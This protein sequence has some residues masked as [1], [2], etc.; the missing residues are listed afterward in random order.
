ME[1][2]YIYIILIVFTYFCASTPFGYLLAKTKNIDI[3]KEGSGN[4]GATNILRTIGFPYFLLVAILDV[5]KI[6][7]PIFLAQR[8]GLSDTH[9][10]IVMFIAIMGSMYSFWLNFKGGK[11]VSA[12]FAALLCIIGVKYFLMF[13]AIWLA[14][15]YILKIMSVTN[16]IIV[17]ILPII[18]YSI[19]PNSTP[20]IYLSLTFIP[21]IWWSH[22]ENIKRL[23]KGKEPKI[24]KF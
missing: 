15:L 17:F 2:T 11:A 13:L 19:I 8:L 4:V 3:Q 1:S 5:A 7:L 12:I 6:A 14:L 24:I 20:Y 22:R 10:V 18:I 9:I 21:I 23:V 16:L